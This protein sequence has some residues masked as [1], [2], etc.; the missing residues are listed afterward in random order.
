LPE[1]AKVQKITDEGVIFK[2]D[3][4]IGYIRDQD[5]HVIDKELYNV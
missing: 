1:V 5:V 4:K 3:D 2:Y